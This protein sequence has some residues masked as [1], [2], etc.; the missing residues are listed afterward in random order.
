[1]WN[2]P[3]RWVGG[4]ERAGTPIAGI[5]PGVQASRVVGVRA[6]GPDWSWRYPTSATE[7]FK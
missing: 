5:V 7:T 1:M 3:C 4:A 2:M 6:S